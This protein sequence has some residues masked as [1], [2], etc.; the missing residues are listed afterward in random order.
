MDLSPITLA[1]S[2]MALEPLSLDHADELHQ[3]AS[4]DRAS[5][6]FTYVPDGK[7]AV[8]RYIAG[9]LAT[10]A[11][12]PTRVS[13]VS[14]SADEA[15]APHPQNRPMSLRRK[16]ADAP[17]TAAADTPSTTSRSPRGRPWSKGVP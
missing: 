9:A 6:A 2:I 3:A 1:G 14:L 16:R 10:R 15:T 17:T 5:Y 11:F 4:D 8:S 13:A 12:A 7:D